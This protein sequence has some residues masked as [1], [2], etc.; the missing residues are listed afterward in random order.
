MPSSVA[1][2]AG[3]QGTTPH[4]GPC[5]WVAWPRLP[6]L[7]AYLGGCNAGAAT[8][9]EGSSV[10]RGC[11]LLCLSGLREEGLAVVQ[12]A[13]GP[14]EQWTAAPALNKGTARADRARASGGGGRGS[15]VRA[16]GWGHCPGR[17]QEA[18]SEDPSVPLPPHLSHCHPV[19]VTSHLQFLQPA[20]ALPNAVTG[21][22]AS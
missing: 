10:G 5:C 8:S 7:S 21:L 20:P 9:V 19:T 18:A 15:R 2:L 16:A 11:R 17:A 3:Q 22:F 14:A 6:A 1:W 12:R 4:L 13:R